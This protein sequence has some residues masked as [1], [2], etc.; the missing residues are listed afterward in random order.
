MEKYQN[1]YEMDLWNWADEFRN[2]ENR[3]AMNYSLSFIFYRFLSEKLETFINNEFKAKGIEF[4]IDY[5][6]KD[7]K[8][9]MESRA[10]TGIGYF[11]EPDY[12]F[13][14]I[15]IKAKEG[16]YILDDLKKALKYIESSAK[17]QK[18]EKA[19]INI[20]ENIKFDSKNIG[21]TDLD[22]NSTISHIL[23]RLSTVKFNVENGNNTFDHIFKYLI[24]NF[25]ASG[26]RK[27]G[28]FYTPQN[29]SQI[30]AKIVTIGKDEINSVYDPT[31]GSGSLLLKVS[32]EARVEKYYGQEINSE[33]YNLARMNM[34]IHNVHY[35][36]FDIK[37]GNTLENPQHLDKKF[38]AIL[39]FPP[40]SLK[41]SSAKDF[42]GDERFRS[43]NKLGPSTKSDFAFI[44]HMIYQL[45]ENGTMAVIMPR[46]VLFRGGTEKKIRKYLIEEKNYLDSVIGLP[47]NIFYGTGSSAVILV[48]KKSR[49]NND[50]L[51]IDASKSFE[52][53]RPQNIIGKDNINRIIESYMA[54]TDIDKFAYVASLDK[55]RKNEYNLNIPRYVDIFEEESIDKDKLIEELKNIEKEVRKLDEDIVMCCNEL[56]V[57][58]PIF[59][60]DNI[61]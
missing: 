37:L 55:V 38:D 30:L 23:I 51:F 16:R 1:N 18:S 56:G 21:K 15:V 8:E 32:E 40:F 13:K 6:D 25:A 48:F 39:A 27:D 26:G 52:K 14:E 24:A 47:A 34:I 61:V 33:I 35:E 2:F 46:G 12:L 3:E 7:L 19:L 31:C 9:L 49:D 17:G 29:V 20:F 54:R 4:T 41:W 11:L 59:I 50:I 36:N 58:K 57:G 42:V 60:N 10:R 53:S 45:D 44:Q 43:Y 28:A 5:Y 22:K